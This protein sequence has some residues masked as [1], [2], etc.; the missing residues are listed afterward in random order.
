MIS[1]SGTSFLKAVAILAVLTIHILSSIKPSPFVNG[2]P[3][4]LFAV[5]LDQLARISVPLFV[6]ISGYG[7][8]VS[9]SSKEF[10]IVSFFTKRVLKVLPL[11][12]LWSCIFALVFFFIPAWGTVTEQPNFAW[13]LLLGR[14]DYHLY[15][16]PM[17]FQLYVF[18]PVIL[19]FFNRVP[20][21]TLIVAIVIQLTWWW[22]FSY[23]GLTV[24]SWRY[25]AEDGEQY[26][27]MTNWI[28]YFVL[29]M[30]LPKIWKVFDKN[31]TLFFVLLLF[32]I[33]SAIFTSQNAL[34][35]IQ[36]GIDPLFAL[37]FTRYPLFI[38][39]FL[40]IIVLSYA[41]TKLKKI[42]STFAKLGDISYS[43]YLAHTLFLRIIFSILLFL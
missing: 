32:T 10:E 12:I 8:A 38:Y 26:I 25:F 21:T 20:L 33:G 37:K 13:Q 34:T 23:Q 31:K 18:F 2:S 41:V 22:F 24:T 35:A 5:S 14:S 19:Y 6:A 9:Y 27:W 29:G 40:T 15:F 39:G 3:F 43:V 28:A 1:K 11:Y 42:N 17:I 16:V 4:Q 7:I 36:E 30:Y